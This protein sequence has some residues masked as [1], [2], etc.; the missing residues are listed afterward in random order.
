MFVAIAAVY[1]LHQ[2]VWLWRAPRP[3]VFGVLPPGLAY[4]AAYCLAAA[5]LMWWLT[6]VAWPAHLD[7][8]Q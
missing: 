2:D 8:K 6:K 7:T 4:H 5:A 1:L 3:L